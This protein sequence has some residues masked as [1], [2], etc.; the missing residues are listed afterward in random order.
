M[1]STND[2]QALYGDKP[3]ER[4]PMLSDSDCTSRNFWPVPWNDERSIGAMNARNFYESLITKGEL[5]VVKKVP[6]IW[7]DGYPHCGAC[8]ERLVR[9][10]NS[11][12]PGCACEIIKPFK[13]DD[14][15][16]KASDAYGRA[17]MGGG[18]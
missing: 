17:E 8:N 12:C 16:F 9:V 6:H 4:A 3:T 18:A 5:R 10:Y 11:F 7:I 1:N 15:S 14:H 13:L 2:P